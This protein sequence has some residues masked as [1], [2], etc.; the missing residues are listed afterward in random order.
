MR[1]GWIEKNN[2]GLPQVHPSMD[3]SCFQDSNAVEY[4]TGAVYSDQRAKSNGMITAL[5][6]SFKNELE[7]AIYCAVV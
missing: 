3:L 5:M 4:L 2:Q 6:P 7:L 1:C